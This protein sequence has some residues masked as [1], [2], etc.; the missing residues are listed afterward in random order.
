MGVRRA[1]RGSGKPH[2]W[3]VT[4]LY[5]IFGA[6]FLALLWAYPSP[7]PER[8]HKQMTRYRPTYVP[9]VA[10]QL[11]T[12]AEEAPGW[13]FTDRPFYAAQAG[14]LV[15]PPIA[16]LS[17]K[18]LESGIIGPERLR[19]VL[20][21]YRPSYVLLERFTSE[22]GPLFMD[23]LDTHYDPVLIVPPARYYRRKVF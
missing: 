1:S 8:L 13:V 15:P 4:A 9:L 6:V 21:D 23:E 12:D 17:R 11:M 14:L 19:E 7:L 20:R 10:E 2:R 18:R 16:V 3:A 22:Y 5:A